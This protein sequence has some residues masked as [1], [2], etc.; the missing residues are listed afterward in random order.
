MVGL[1]C[2]RHP[3]R[4]ASTHRTA[5]RGASALRH[6]AD[7]GRHRG[8]T[9]AA[10]DPGGRDDAGGAAARPGERAG[11]VTGGEGGMSAKVTIGGSVVVHAVLADATD[12]C[13]AVD[14]VVVAAADR[15]AA[16]DLPRA[17]GYRKVPRRPARS[18]R[19]DASAL[20]VA[21][22]A[23]GAVF[24]RR[25][26]TG[27]PW[28]GP[29]PPAG[30]G[31]AAAQWALVRF[32]AA[33]VPPGT[34]PEPTAPGPPAPGPAGPGPSAPGGRDEAAGPWGR[35]LRG[36][37]DCPSRVRPPPPAPGALRPRRPCPRR[38]GAVAGRPPR[39]PARRPRTRLRGRWSRP[40]R[41]R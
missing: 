39:P 4:P 5:T 37:W 34:G 25:V 9:A 26:G 32:P 17:H 21:F 24:R 40:S 20:D 13:D 41:R 7:W 30:T 10:R 1:R 6:R 27:G 29:A 12:A 35:R 18:G 31:T 19:I 11:V 14:E 36:P 3:V 38:H 8:G 15:R 33:G 23:P 28:R 2:G 22:A 16:T